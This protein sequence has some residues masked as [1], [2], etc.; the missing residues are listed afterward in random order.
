MNPS[1]SVV[2]IT[3]SDS[4]EAEK[5]ARALVEGGLVACANMAPI[6][7]IYQWEGNVKKDEEVVLLCKTLTERV[8]DV[9]ARVRQLH[10]Y[11][12][13]CI[14]HWPLGGGSGVYMRWVGEQTRKT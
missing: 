4:A 10:S 12:M 13:P 2:Y 1:Y 9:V 7:S 8:D 3:A 6:T 5:I 14:T 11:E